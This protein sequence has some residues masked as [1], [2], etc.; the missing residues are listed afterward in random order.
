MLILENGAHLMRKIFNISLH[1]IT[2][3]FEIAS[4]S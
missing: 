2:R 4:S 1:M 3:I